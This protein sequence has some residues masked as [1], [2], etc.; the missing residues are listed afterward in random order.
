[1]KLKTINIDRPVTVLPQEDYEGL[2]ETLAILQNKKIL[3]RI[4]SALTN[5]QKGK[6]FSHQ[7][8]FGRAKRSG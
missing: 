5:I 3:S 1:M 4:Q 2:L 6:I 8:V 7:E